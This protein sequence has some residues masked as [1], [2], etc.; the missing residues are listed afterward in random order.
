MKLL[1][2]AFSIV[3]LVVVSLGSSGCT[4][5]FRNV[6]GLQKAAEGTPAIETFKPKHA[7]FEVSMPGPRDEV[8]TDDIMKRNYVYKHTDGTYSLSF[9][10]VHGS[11]MDQTQAQAALDELCDKQVKSIDGKVT[12]S[13]AIEYYGAAGEQTVVR[14][15]KEIEGTM[16][17][18][19]QVFKLRMYIIGTMSFKTSYSLIV[20]GK[21]PF[22]NSSEAE[23]FIS[24]LKLLD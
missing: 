17:N 19:D 22:V 3:I 13:K 4:R 8:A 12:S 7:G 18:G 15:G 6:M 9:G 23:R 24:S 5:A 11:I 16:G 1:Q 10:L 21:K 14:V 2:V 20:F